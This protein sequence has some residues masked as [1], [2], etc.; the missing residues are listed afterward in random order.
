MRL[1]F[2]AERQRMAQDQFNRQARDSESLN[3][4]NQELQEQCTRL[5]IACTRTS[6][7]LSIANSHIE[8]LRNEN[9]NLRSEKQI[10]E[11]RIL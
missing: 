8:R 11:V 10:W 1:T 6:E 9:I 2:L 4:R 7:E 3:K 5:E